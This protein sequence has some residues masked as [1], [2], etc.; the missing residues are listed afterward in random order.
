MKLRTGLFALM[1]SL[2]LL[3][4]C[5]PSG[6]ADRKVFEKFR[7]GLGEI[8]M[9]AK[10]RADYGDAVSDFVLEFAE[11]DDKYRINV[12]EPALISGCRVSISKDGADLEYEGIILSVG[13]LSREGMTPVTVLPALVSALREWKLADI[14]REGGDT[15]LLMIE[16]ADLDNMTAVFWLDE[17]MILKRAELAFEGYTVAYCDITKWN[18]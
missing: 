4:G 5:M 17:K 18:A 9:T 6:Q 16:L 11:S 14:R 8:S 2:C 12:L 10:L 13:E 15:P 1:I 3:T 7:E